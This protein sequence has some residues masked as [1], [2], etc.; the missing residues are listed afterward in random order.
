MLDRNLSRR[1]SLRL[2]YLGRQIA[3]F[4]VLPPEKHTVWGLPFMNSAFPPQELP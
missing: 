3:Q 4:G 1:D 2:I